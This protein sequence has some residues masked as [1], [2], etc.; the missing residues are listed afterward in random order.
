MG[1][2]QYVAYFKHNYIICSI[3]ISRDQSQFAWGA[4]LSAKSDILIALFHWNS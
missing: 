4:S 3:S 2:E 1:I